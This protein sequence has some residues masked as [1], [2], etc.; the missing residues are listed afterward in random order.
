MLDLGEELALLGRGVAVVH[1]ELER[2]AE[3]DLV[4]FLDALAGGV[5]HRHLDLVT[6]AV[7]RGDLGLEESGVAQVGV[8]AGPDGLGTG[9]PGPELARGEELLDGKGVQVLEDVGRRDLVE[10]A[11]A[12]GGEGA[13]PDHLGVLAV[14]ELEELGEGQAE[15]LEVGVVALDV[16]EL[17]LG[18]GAGALVAALGHAAVA[19]DVV[20]LVLG[21]Q[22]AGE[23]PHFHDLL[24]QLELAL[25]EWRAVGVAEGAAH[26]GAVGMR[27]AAELLALM[28]GEI[29]V[30]AHDRTH[31]DGA[32]L[33]LTLLV[34]D[35][36]VGREGLTAHMVGL[37][38]DHVVEIARLLEV[39]GRRDA[40]RAAAD[41]ADA[42][43][44]VL[45]RHIRSPIRNHK[46]MVNT[47]WKI[48][49]ARSIV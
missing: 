23:L 4:E 40:G 11:V 43:I 46:H 10:V 15:V 35:L 20:A 25:L 39:H 8:D 6:R 33:P 2:G 41:Y 47:S 26:G 31:L 29:G 7:H 42:L 30:A 1:E 22:Q 49:H 32:I 45:V 5:A 38:V 36:H 37:L 48:I 17:E 27:G 28:H 19:V 18:R 9:A 34:L 3:D 24:E 16:G 44:P 14:V 21:G 13:L 12:E